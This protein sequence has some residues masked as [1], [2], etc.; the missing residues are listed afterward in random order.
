MQIR[1]V[2]DQPWEAPTDVLVVPVV[3][4]PDFDGPLRRARP[5]AGGE[6]RALPGV[7]R[8]PGQALRR[9]RCGAAGELP[10]RARARRLGAAQA[11]ELDRETVRKF[12]A[13]GDPAADRPRRQG[14]GGLARPARRRRSA[15]TSRWPPSSSRGASSR[16][17]FE[18]KT[19]YREDSDAAPPALDELVLVAPGGDAGGADEGRRARPDHGRGR[20][21]RAPARRTG[22]RTTSRR[23]SSPTRRARSP[24]RNGL[25]ID[26]IDEKRAAELGMGMFLAVGQGSDEPAAD[27]RDA[28][29][30]RGR[31]GRAGPAP[32]DGRQGRLL[33]LR[34][35]QH[36]ARPTGWKR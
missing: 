31:E 26:V 9:P 20:E 2:T 15:G 12:A 32:R 13:T 10:A 7:R 5:S 28:V 18:P 3:G 8:A 6:L 27:D 21:H 35:H 29:G 16:A 23:R 22:P 25:S 11:E 19:I 24:R 1:V 14:D 4:E 34:R 33:R 36:Q 30:R 17:A